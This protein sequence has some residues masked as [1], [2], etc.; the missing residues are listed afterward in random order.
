MMKR[1]EDMY[2][3]EYIGG[4]GSIG[5]EGQGKKDRGRG[6]GKEQ[7]GDGYRKGRCGG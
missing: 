7:Q 2:C 6:T 5:E 1:V 4:E 3:E